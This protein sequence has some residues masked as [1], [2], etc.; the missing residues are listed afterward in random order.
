[1]QAADTVGVFQIESRAQMATLPRMK[2]RTFYDVVIEVA[3]IRPGPIQGKMV[4]PYLARRSGK[5]PIDYMHPKLEPVLERTLGVPLFQEQVLKMAMVMADFS[6]SEAEELRRAMSFQRSRERMERVMRKLREAMAARGV[7]E[8]S[9]E[10]IIT[11]I[12]SF[13]L[14]GF[15][16][17]HAISFA[18][19]SYASAWLKAHRAAEF[20]TSLLNNQPMGFYSSAT[21][22]QDARRHGL[23]V[24]PVCVNISDWDCAVESDDTFRLGLRVVRSM[25]EEPARSMVAARKERVFSSMD[26]FRRRTSFNPAERRALASVGALNALAEHRREALWQVEESLEED[27]WEW[28]EREN[29]PPITPAPENVVSSPLEAMTPTERLRADYHGMGLTTG[30]HPM[31]RLRRQ[32]TGVCRALDLAQGRDGQRVTIAGSVI[33]RQRPGTAKGFV[34]ISLEDETGIANA[35]VTPQM[36]EENRLTIS[37]EPFLRIRGVLQNQEGV[38]SVKAEKIEPLYETNLPAEKSHDFH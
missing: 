32:L 18:L 21:L 34:F 16:E 23:R 6:G 33:C 5:Q 22:I 12:S 30:S 10:E 7:P 20:Y 4:H 17:S 11:S 9:I 36:F 31:R 8:K 26:D 27:L 29:A 3:L 24:K 25:R 19:I 1:M 38:I 37:Q 15:P 28:G 2:P 35:I 13:A 14:Y